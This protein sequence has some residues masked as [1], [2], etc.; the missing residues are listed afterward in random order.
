MILISLF[1]INTHVM[2][3]HMDKRIRTKFESSGT[4]SVKQMTCKIHNIIFASQIAEDSDVF[5]KHGAIIVNSNQIVASGIN[6]Q[7]KPRKRLMGLY[8]HMN[9]GNT[10]HAEYAAIYNLITS[11]KFTP[12][13]VNIRRMKLDLYVARNNLR[14]SKPCHHCINLLKYWGI[15]RVFYTDESE[16]IYKC[17]KISDI[18]NEHVSNGNINGMF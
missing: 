10:I 17:E 1:T 8:N 9:C 14:N 4:S 6:K 5:S 13:S 3:D 15:Y 16:D 7:E 18:V 2:S 11:T 12:N